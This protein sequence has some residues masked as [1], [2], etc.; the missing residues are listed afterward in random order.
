MNNKEKIKWSIFYQK[1]A[2]GKIPC[3]GSS[4]CIVDNYVSEDEVNA[5][6]QRGRGMD[7]VQYKLVTPTQQYVEQTK[8]TLK[9]NV[10]GIKYNLVSPTQQ[11]VEQAK[12]TLKR[13]IQE[14]KKRKI[15]QFY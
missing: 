13:N 1:M 7:D 9:R 4:Y 14:G 2:D 3:T 5:E 8:E 11:H 15:A 10:D 6:Y 12:A